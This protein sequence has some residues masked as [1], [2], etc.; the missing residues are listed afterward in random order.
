LEFI[1]FDKTAFA[2]G[3][4]HLDKPG[5]E[6]RKVEYPLDRLYYSSG[7]VFDQ[8]PGKT[9]LVFFI[10]RYLPVRVLFYYLYY[11]AD[12]PAR[13]GITNS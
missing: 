10:N 1:G 2:Y 9:S 7:L 6:C 12:N 3:V 8:A 5:F 13:F 4:K 11:M